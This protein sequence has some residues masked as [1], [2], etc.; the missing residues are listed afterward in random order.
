MSDDNRDPLIIDLPIA[1]RGQHSK[2]TP[3]RLATNANESV[4]LPPQVLPE[5][6]G[7]AAHG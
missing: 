4:V 1:P 7:F 5:R 2:D 3:P 6:P